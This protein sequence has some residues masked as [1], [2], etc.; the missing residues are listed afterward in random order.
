MLVDFHSVYDRHAPRLRVINVAER[1]E[2]LNGRRERAPQDRTVIGTEDTSSA[3]DVR[4]S[5]SGK[6][7][8]LTK[9]CRWQ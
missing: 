2:R 8:S 1:D 4:P 5:L 7:W 9:V 3:S 6:G